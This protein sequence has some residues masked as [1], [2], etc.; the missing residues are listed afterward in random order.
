MQPI[1]NYLIQW[2]CMCGFLL[3][4][5]RLFVGVKV[6]SLEE[7][8]CIVLSLSALDLNMSNGDWTL[9]LLTAEKFMSSKDC[10]AFI[11]KSSHTGMYLFGLKFI[12]IRIK[13]NLYLSTL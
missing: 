6:I 7:I 9:Q 1:K 2:N 12:L 3:V 13:P 5:G 8:F 11:F 10:E 4:L